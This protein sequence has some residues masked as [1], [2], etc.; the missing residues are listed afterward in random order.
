MPQTASGTVARVGTLVEFN[1]MCQSSENRGWIAR[2]PRPV[3]PIEPAAIGRA[4]GKKVLVVNHVRSQRYRRPGGSGRELID[5]FKEET[6]S[7][8]G[9]RERQSA[10]Y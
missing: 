10:G 6:L 1:E 9:P 4:N 3:Q 8:C 2:L 7:S 5:S